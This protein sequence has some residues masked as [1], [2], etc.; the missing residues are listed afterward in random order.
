ML[1]KLI[2]R[3]R[4]HLVAISEGVDELVDCG[5]IAHAR[6][7]KLACHAHA[8]ILA[9]DISEHKQ[10]PRVPLPRVPPAREKNLHPTRARPESVV[11]TAEGDHNYL[12]RAEQPQRNS[13]LP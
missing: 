10:R 12:G 7:S 1:V 5:H 9:H 2:Q 4:E 13:L 3:T 8:A 6:P 11:R